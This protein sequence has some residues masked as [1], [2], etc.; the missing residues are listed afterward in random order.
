MNDHTPLDQSRLS[1]AAQRALGPGPGKLMA[2]RGIVPLPPLDQVAVL[3]QLTFDSDP[4]V[5]QAARDTAAKLPEKLLAGTLAD[6]QN[7]PRVLDYFGALM[8]DKPSVFDAVALNP[9][10]SDATITTLAG[11]CGAREVDLLAQNEQRILRTPEIIA[12]MYMNRKARMSTIDRVVELAVRNQVRVP[13]LAAW[14][15]VARALAGAPATTDPEDDARFDAVIASR[16]DSSLTAGDGEEVPVDD[17]G[18]TSRLIEL[19]VTVPNQPA[20]RIPLR[21][22]R[23]I[24]G[25]DPGTEGYVPNVPSQWLVAQLDEDENG[26]TIGIVETRETIHA[27][28]KQHIQ[29][30]NVRL[31]L[32]PTPFRDLPIPHKVRAATLGDAFVRAEAIRDSNKMVSLA[33]IKSPGVTDSEAAA[34]AGNQVLSE[35]VIRYIAGR[36]EWTKLYGVKVSLCRNPKAPIAETTRMMP[37]LRERDINELIKSK[38]VPSAVVAQARKIQMQRRGGDRK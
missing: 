3:Y 32:A 38:G 35:D 16:D 4:T 30:G 27:A 18:R 23:T 36:R 7:D 28:I 25:G 2:A 24:I 37:F 10:T 6:P 15:E 8:V 17:G 20:T 13:G 11:R 31:I 21:R 14:D 26:I 5:A 22:M 29:I 1:P 33:A 19:H 34:Y 9:S 12:A